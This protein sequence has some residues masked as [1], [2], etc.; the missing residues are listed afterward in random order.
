MFGE[1]D[2]EYAITW[3]IEDEVFRTALDFEAV[4]I[5][6]LTDARPAVFIH[7]HKV[8]DAIEICGLVL[9]L[10][11]CSLIARIECWVGG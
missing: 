9:A 7:G 5:G 2:N 11:S 1:Y 4:I 10:G 8:F 3:S 6:N